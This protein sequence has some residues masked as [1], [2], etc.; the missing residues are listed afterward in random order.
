MKTR[1]FTIKRTVS[2][3]LLSTKDSLQPTACKRQPATNRLQTTA[4]NQQPATNSLQTTA[5]KRQPATT[6]AADDNDKSLITSLSFDHEFI[7]DHEFE[8]RS[9][10]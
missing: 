8:F 6:T 5:C 9:R 2:Y 1:G 3:S 7:L 4:C 10:V